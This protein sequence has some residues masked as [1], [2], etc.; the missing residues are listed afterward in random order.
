MKRL[1]HP[2]YLALF[3]ILFLLPV[4]FY[5]QAEKWM[6]P[7]MRAIQQEIS[8]NAERIENLD[9]TYLTA[10][11]R[12]LQ[13]ALA[14]DP[15]NPLLHYAMGQH[16]LNLQGK[17]E[18]LLGYPVLTDAEEQSLNEGTMSGIRLGQAQEISKYRVEY[19]NKARKYL[20]KASESGYAPLQVAYVEFL[21]SGY[22]PQQNLL[23]KDYAPKIQSINS[24]TVGLLESAYRQG[25]VDAGRAL[26]EIYIKG[27][28]L[29]AQD[30]QKGEQYLSQIQTKLK[31]P[32]AVY[33][34]LGYGFLTAPKTRTEQSGFYFSLPLAE[35]FLKKASSLTSRV[36]DLWLG[37]MYYGALGQ[38]SIQPPNLEKAAFHLSRG[39]VSA[40]ETTD[41]YLML[42]SL[43]LDGLGGLKKD[44]QRAKEMLKRLQSLKKHEA[45]L[46]FVDWQSMQTL[47]TQLLGRTP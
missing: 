19:S 37:Y 47:I 41:G 28:G 33:D 15:Q 1:L 25:N 21:R 14:K 38:R 42:A 7:E 40:K 12:K 5:A 44:P 31:F 22:Y 36:S 9:R 11:E 23:L 13:A 26:G 34:E 3:L 20:K 18:K 4:C 35:R 43:H 45:T 24:V 16:F 30:V 10:L 2:F 27:E 8:N 32:A 6:T 39:V 17:V 46:D 29:V